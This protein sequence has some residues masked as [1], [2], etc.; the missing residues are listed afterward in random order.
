MTNDDAP[1]LTQE[2]ADRLKRDGALK[3]VHPDTKPVY[4]GNEAA[5]Q[6]ALIE[7]R[8]AI[9]F[10]WG[11]ICGQNSLLER[12]IE[13]IRPALEM[14]KSAARRIEDVLEIPE[15]QRVRYFKDPEE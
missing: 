2:E 3:V 6:E 5:Y 10:M 11:V 15:D 8:S 4:T 12:D 13:D 14:G 7:A 1:E 9:S